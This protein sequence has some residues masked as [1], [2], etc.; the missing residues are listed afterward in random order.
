MIGAKKGSGW[1]IIDS[2]G[3]QMLAF[4]F[5]E[6]PTL[7][8]DNR[9][10]VKLRGVP[11][12]ATSTGTIISPSG[13]DG[14][15][16]LTARQ[17][18]STGIYENV[19]L[20]K[21]KRGNKYGLHSSTGTLLLEPT[22]ENKLY[23]HSSGL[24]YIRKTASSQGAY[25]N[26][27]GTILTDFIYDE[28]FWLAIFEQAGSLCKIHIGSLWGVINSEGKEVLPIGYERVWIFDDGKTF[29]QSSPHLY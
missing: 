7:E 23:F 25:I 5:D 17:V 19:G 1:G 16:W 3:R 20:I 27:Q 9:Y 4:L 13:Y 21:S 12:I 24:A 10:A 22:A 15:E 2:T 29:C 8:A 26:T 6:T 28:P 14:C 18:S 11:M